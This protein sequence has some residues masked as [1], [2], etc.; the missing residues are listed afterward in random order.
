MPYERRLSQVSRSWPKSPGHRATARP[1]AASRSAR[2]ADGLLLA[3]PAPRTSTRSTPRASR[4]STTWRPSSPKRRK[5]YASHSRTDER[6]AART[7]DSNAR[8]VSQ[9]TSSTCERT[10]YRVCART[11]SRGDYLNR[12]VVSR[13]TP[14][15]LSVS[16]GALPRSACTQLPEPPQV[17][18]AESVDHS[19]RTNRKCL[20]RF[21][22]RLD[23]P[24]RAS[25]RRERLSCH[26]AQACRVVVHRPLTR[27]PHECSSLLHP[28][29][30]IR[31][32]E[33]PR[34]DSRASE[35]TAGAAFPQ[36]LHQVQL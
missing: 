20:P 18:C 2:G 6:S 29:H 24:A 8:M 15:R 3:R 5:S 1:S 13:E 27:Q 17:S 7:S 22:S 30:Q 32:L 34:E 28:L 36:T 26:P 25:G 11:G 23:Q 4:T 12:D 10:D 19:R 14:N 31:L 16:H 9:R 33:P 21:F 35:A